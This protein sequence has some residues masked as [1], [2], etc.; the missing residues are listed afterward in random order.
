MDRVMATFLEHLRAAGLALP[1]NIRRLE[2]CRDAAHVSGCYVYS[3]GTRR[4]HMSIREAEGGRLLLVVRVGGGF[5]DF[6]RFAMRHGSLENLRLQRRPQQDG[7]Q[8]VR[9]VGV[10]GCHNERRVREMPVT[11]VG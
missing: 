8:V 6:V 4:L 1:E 7:R 3:F 2:H 9:L 5:V 10:L 11:I